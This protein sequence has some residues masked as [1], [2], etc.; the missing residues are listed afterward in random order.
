MHI[1]DHYGIDLAS[2]WRDELTLGELYAR[3]HRVA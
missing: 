2:V 3:V 1:E